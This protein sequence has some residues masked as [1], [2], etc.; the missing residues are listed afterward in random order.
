MPNPIILGTVALDSVETP[1]G[2]HR[3][4]LGG[5][6]S[7]AAFAASFFAK[8]GIVS[9]VG[10][11]FPEEHLDLLA[12]KHINLAGIQKRGASFR[13]EGV[14]EY[15]MHEANTTH[16]ILGS[17]IDFEPKLPLEYQQGKYVFLANIDPEMQ[18]QVIEQL[19]EPKLT[20]LDTRDLWIK[21]KPDALK[22]AIRKV[23]ILLLND[24]EA[25]QLFETPNLV[26]AAQEALKMGVQGVIIKK[27]EHGA[28]L[29]TEGKH[30]N[31][32]G[33]PLEMIKDP[34]G[35]GDAFGGALLGYLAKTG[36]ISEK[37]LRKAIV[38][39]SALASFNAEDFSL[40]RMKKLTWN[41]IEKRV[42]EF[43]T[44]REF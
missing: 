44:M 10:T 8:P 4:I 12:A 22:K 2:K 15:T 27:G 31:A 38:Y 33:Y 26:K 20:L 1:F 42:H 30:F 32:P 5:S 28:L 43:R 17:L 7:Y 18:L 21:T 19:V 9:I 40:E 34:T 39:G 29:F 35:C 36:D 6:A 37:N 16:L 24:A 14:Y 13:W 3:N 23:D 41:D 25:R 11:D